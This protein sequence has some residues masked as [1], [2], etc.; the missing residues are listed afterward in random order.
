MAYKALDCLVD[1]KVGTRCIELPISKPDVFKKL[2]NSIERRSR[3][4][5]G[6]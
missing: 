1:G 2:L 4:F 3:Y 5:I 6:F